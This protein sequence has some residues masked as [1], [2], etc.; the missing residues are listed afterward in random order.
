MTWLI[1]DIGKLFVFTNRNHVV[2]KKAIKILKTKNSL[3]S[4]AFGAFLLFFSLFPPLIPFP[5]SSQ[6]ET[7]P[8][9][10]F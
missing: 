3:S 4:L 7:I 6:Q 1:L 5:L 10:S 9:H 2:K 8:E